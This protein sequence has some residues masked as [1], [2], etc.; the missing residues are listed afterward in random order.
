MN[1]YKILIEFLIT[2]IILY[3]FYYFFVIKKC[4]KTKNYVPMEVNLILS[5]HKIDYRSIDLYK[6]IKITSM[7]TVLILSIIITFISN[8]FDST[9]LVIL[10]GTILSIIIAIIC[11]NYIGYYFKKVSLK[12]RK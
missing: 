10:F 7:V 11:Y 6:M 2:I 1:Y 5:I 4:K 9:I 8:F 12:K 3:L